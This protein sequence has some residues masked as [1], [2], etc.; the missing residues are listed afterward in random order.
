MT[1]LFHES[2][3]P[4]IGPVRLPSGKLVHG[5]GRIL[6]GLRAGDP[7]I[8]AQR[9][10]PGINAERLQT[11]LLAR[12]RHQHHLVG[13]VG[14]M[15]PTNGRIGPR[16]THLDNSLYARALRWARALLLRLRGPL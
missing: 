5:T 12:P 9:R 7:P 16:I 6:I 1:M 8:A 3:P 13:V 15:R 14:A 10:D 11:A 2:M 4:L